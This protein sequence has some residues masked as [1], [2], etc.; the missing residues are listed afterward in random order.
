MAQALATAAGPAGG[1][2]CVAGPP[3]SSNGASSFHLFWEMPRTS[4]ASRL[5]EVS[6][7]LEVLEPPQVPSLYF[8]AMQVDF[9]EDGLPWGGGH[10]GLQWN[11][12]FPGGTAVNWGGYASQDRAVA[13]SIYLALRAQGHSV[14]FDRADL[15]PGDEYDTRIRQA[16]ERAQLFVFLL[17]PDS[18]DAG[19][20]TLT[21]LAIA[22][23]TWDSPA[24]IIA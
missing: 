11:R 9:E 13:E 19:S 22:Q 4:Q 21:E 16:I 23:K 1:G 14:F 24:K 12:R 18:V 7:V 3:R 8:W 17:S 10:T 5:I 20:Y 15:P 2:P 6:A